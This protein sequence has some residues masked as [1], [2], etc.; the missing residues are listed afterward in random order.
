MKKKFKKAA[1]PKWLKHP[2]KTPYLKLF[3]KHVRKHTKRA[4]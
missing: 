3:I 4:N 1:T 2:V